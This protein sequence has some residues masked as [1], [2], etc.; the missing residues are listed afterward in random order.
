MACQASLSH[1]LKGFVTHFLHRDA[2]LSKRTGVS[3]CDELHDEALEMK[4]FGATSNNSADSRTVIF[5]Q[6]KLVFDKTAVLWVL[7]NKT[8]T[9]WHLYKIDEFLG[10]QTIQLVNTIKLCIIIVNC[11]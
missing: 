9:Y 6:F 1:R 8:E 10:C 11:N 4:T 2:F 5:V 7:I 3:S